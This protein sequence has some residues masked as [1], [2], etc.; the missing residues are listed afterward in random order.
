MA[1]QVL[2]GIKGI[3]WHMYRSYC[4]AS[5]LLHCIKGVTWNR[6]VLYG[7]TGG[8]A[9]HRNYWIPSQMVLHCIAGIL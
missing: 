3:A 7:I 9:L 6:K 2:F 5:Q 1:S 8:V 4:I